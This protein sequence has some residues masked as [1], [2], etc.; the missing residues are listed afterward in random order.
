[1]SNINEEMNELDEGS[2]AMDSL[3]PNSKP[4]KDDPKSK[5]EILNQMIGAAHTMKSDELTKW[6]EQSMALIGKEASHLPGHANEKSNENSIRMKPSHATGKG[7]ASSN[8][9]MPKISVKEDVEEMFSGDDLSEE[10]KEKASVLFEAALNARVM[11]EVTRLEEEYETTINEA[12]QSV[13][14]EMSTKLDSY[15]D[16]VVENWMKENEVAIEST[17][18]NEIA[19]EFMGGLKNL[20]AEHYID[21]PEEKIDVVESLAD[22][23]ERLEQHIDSLISENVQLKEGYAEVEKNNIVESFLEDLAYSQQEKFKALAEGIDFDG[24]DL[25]TYA[26]KLSIIKESYFGVEKR[27]VV[28]TNIMEESFEGETEAHQI[29]MDP[30]ISKYSQAISRSIK[31]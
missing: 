30:V 29:S 8:D 2:L 12:I 6:F 7:G 21:L 17:L 15:L 4:T 23:V 19:E 1:M 26:R 10:F 31:R 22:K 13:H 24:S 25:D 18:R 20:F 5:V 3:K 28:S 27:P 16:F 9:P 14:E 11:M